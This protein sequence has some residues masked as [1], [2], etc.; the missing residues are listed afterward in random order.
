MGGKYIAW[1]VERGQDPAFW[2]Y[3]PGYPEALG[4]PDREDAVVHG[5]VTPRDVL[6]RD[7]ISRKAGSDHSRA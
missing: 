5:V 6:L 2:C 4:V 3:L 7:A 1:L